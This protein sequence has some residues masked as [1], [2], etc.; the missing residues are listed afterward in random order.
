MALHGFHTLVDPIPSPLQPPGPPAAAS[1]HAM[2][3]QK[4]TDASLRNLRPGQTQLDYWCTSFAGFGVGRYQRVKLGVYP[5]LSLA[6][7]RRRARQVVGEVASD[8]DPAQ[9]RRDARLAPT[10][11]HLANLYMES[12]PA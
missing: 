1:Q 9:A 7:A 6:D 12:T 2:P 4:L 5:E 11:E 10:F 3:K 8:R